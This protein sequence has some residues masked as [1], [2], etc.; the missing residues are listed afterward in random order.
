MWNVDGWVFQPDSGLQKEFCV[1]VAQKS[2]S[3]TNV[4][5]NDGNVAALIQPHSGQ[6]IC[7]AKTD[8]WDDDR[9]GERNFDARG[10]ARY[11]NDHSPAGAILHA[12]NENTVGLDLLKNTDLFM[13]ECEILSRRAIIHNLSVWYPPN[14]RDMAILKPNLERA[15]AAGH[16]WGTHDA[17]YDRRQM[18][19][20]LL[21]FLYL[22]DDLMG[23]RF[24][25]VVFTE[26]GCCYG[27]QALQGYRYGSNPISDVEAGTETVS[28]A[29]RLVVH[30]A[31]VCTFII[32]RDHP[33]NRWVQ[34]VPRGPMLSHI[35]AFPVQWKERVM[36][37]VDY[38]FVEGEVKK[39]PVSSEVSWNVRSS[40]AIRSDNIVTKVSWNE[41]TKEGTK[42][43]VALPPENAKVYGSGYRWLPVQLKDFPDRTLYVATENTTFGRPV[44][45][46]VEAVQHPIVYLGVPYVSQLGE[47]A[48]LRFNDCGI[49]CLLMCYQ[50]ALEKQ[51]LGHNKLIFVDSLIEKTPLAAGDDPLT[52]N[53]MLIIASN[54]GM[55]I[56]YVYPLNTYE[57]RRILDAGVPPIALVA[58]KHIFPEDEFDGG[59]YVVV[60]GYNDL[61]FFINDPYKRGE[62][63]FLTTGAMVLALTETEPY[64]VKDYQGIVVGS[65]E[66]LEALQEEG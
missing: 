28:Q 16:L 39:N 43:L 52:I 9:F 22:R 30:G 12:G 15:V 27:Y 3:R 55:N 21:R 64:A 60:T 29:L 1:E 62:E 17:Y 5:I 19:G 18:V 10:M 56:S 26:G 7:R 36:P 38:K 41:K 25:E 20:P 49:A 42:L 4:V 31:S 63:V 8:R 23:G 59:H 58:Y 6:V 35:W 24:P 65:N 66:M 34:F 11:L 45:I 2:R 14:I 37:E 44:C 54:M 40:P 51:G 33:E 46:I 13:D 57:I 50:Y 61:G 47:D 32:S 53:Q 48:N